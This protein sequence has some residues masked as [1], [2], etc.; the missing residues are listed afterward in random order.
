[1]DATGTGANVRH[2]HRDARR[3]LATA[4]GLGLAATIGPWSAAQ[5]PAT[6][7][8]SPGAS[9]WTFTD[10]KGVTVSLPQA[11]ARIVADVNAAAPLWD[12]GIRPVAVFGWNASDTGDFGAAGG[13]INASDVEIVGNATEPVNVEKLV[14]A[15]PDVIIT[16]TWA[17]DDPSDYWSIDPEILE[18]VRQVAPLVAIS[19]VQRADLALERYAELAVLLDPG[20]ADLPATAEDK[21]AYDEAS[22]TLNELSAAK[23][24]VSVSFIWAEPEQIYVAVPENWG[25]LLLFQHLGLTI[26]APR[27]PSSPYWDELSW[28][29]ALT[30][31]SDV[32]MNSWR[33]EIPDDELRN[34][35]T[36]GPH[37]AIQAGQVGSWNQDFIAS[38]R[39]L[40]ETILS[41]IDVLEPAGNVYDGE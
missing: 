39:G 38:Y 26:V 23:P 8:A 27:E 19:A 11:P 22:A 6:P 25:D 36:F 24:D 20:V 30:Y 9:G 1:M 29:R 10:D 4:G 12:M 35:P 21:A 5:A 32:V 33:S 15:Q 2:F 41:V 37:P 13:R 28:E 31:R 40:A 7:S 34:Q 17:P 18:Q 16:Q 14:A 3:V